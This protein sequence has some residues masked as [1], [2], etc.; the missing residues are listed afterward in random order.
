MVI[1]SGRGR[2]WGAEIGRDGSRALG[3]TGNVRAARHSTLS[4][5]LGQRRGVCGMGPCCHKAA[6]GRT[7]VSS[8]ELVDMGA[9]ERSL[10]DGKKAQVKK[11]RNLP[12]C[13]NLQG[14]QPTSLRNCMCSTEIISHTQ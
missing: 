4:V 2:Q 14:H 10:G 7:L 3:S 1:G 11:D 9:M 8:T 13:N 5:G 12:I 6:G